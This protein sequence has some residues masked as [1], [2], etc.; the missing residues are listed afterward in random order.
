M[1]HPFF[2]KAVL[3]AYDR[4]LPPESFPSYFLYFDV[5][6]ATIDI[7]IHPT[8]TEIKFEDERTA[9][10]II[11]ASLREA[12]GRFNLIPS[13]DFDQAGAIDIP[14]ASDRNPSISAPEIKVDPYYNPFE[15]KNGS[16]GGG[17]YNKPFS[18]DRDVNLDNWEKLYQGFERR[19]DRDDLP[20]AGFIP[21][22]EIHQEP[23][24]Q[25]IS[26]YEKIIRE[27]Q[28]FLQFKNRYILTPVK[29]GLMV[30][31][32]RRAHERVLYEK[33][34]RL[35]GNDFSLSQRQL[36]PSRLE[37]NAADREILLAINEEISALGF[38]LKEEEG[39]FM[40]EGIP[41][42]L[43]HLNANNLI[44]KMLEDF[45]IR[46][47]DVK[48]EI[49]EQLIRSL[50][51]SSAINYGSTLKPEE[52]SE[53]FNNLFSCASPAWSPSG[54]KIITIIT[55]AEFEKLLN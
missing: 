32:Q 23:E 30:I 15:K 8:K 29:S 31:D 7:N 55:F 44:L 53:L 17:S 46:P 1:K 50:S 45:K 25:T 28:S 48:E 10:H 2:H 22:H 21:Q 12:I 14:V 38:E 36:F 4:I 52:I 34:M 5:D 37:L 6:P 41:S 18:G 54:K 43:S 19:T 39:V 13:I 26:E 9:W 51:Q 40:V 35:I 11:H 42:L 33:F 20:S 3:Q 27:T 24:Q 49:K 47:V 16:S